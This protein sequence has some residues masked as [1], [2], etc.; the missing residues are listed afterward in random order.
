MTGQ[1]K[2]CLTKGIRKSSPPSK[3]NTAWKIAFWNVAKIYV[4]CMDLIMH[5]YAQFGG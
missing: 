1:R 3:K 2:H 5:F 4:D